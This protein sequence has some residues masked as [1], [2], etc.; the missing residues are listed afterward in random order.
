LP[1]WVPGNSLLTSHGS[2]N[3]GLYRPE[4]NFRFLA[5]KKSVQ[6]LS[7]VQIFLPRFVNKYDSFELL[8]TALIFVFLLRSCG[9]RGTN[10]S[11]EVSLIILLEDDFGPIVKNYL[12]PIAI[13]GIGS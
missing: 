2:D 13:Q 9:R 1:Q 10:V 8:V 4:E 12:S 6:K 7:S 5:L 11:R 3:S